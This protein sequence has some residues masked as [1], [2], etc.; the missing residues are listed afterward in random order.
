MIQAVIFDMDG[1]LINSEPYWRLAM[2]EAFQEV[3]LPFTEEN[4]RETTG[5]RIDEVVD[6]WYRRTPWKS[7][8]PQAVSLQ[9]IDL[10]KQHV[11][12]SGIALPGVQ[13]TLDLL[14]DQNLRLALA[15]SS[16]MALIDAVL[17]RLNI[18]SYFEV[19]HSAEFEAYGKPHPQVF[20]ST[21][22]KLN[23]KPENC[24]VIEDSLNG[25]IA[26]KAAKMKVI[27]IP[28]AE[29]LNNPAFAIADRQYTSLEQFQ[30]EHLHTL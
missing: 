20:I 29:N 28:E 8:A 10:V 6:L 18:R 19:V 22:E 23:C 26:G 16:S 13:V 7:K 4:C 9:I 17:D 24:V 1:L 5:F 30:V 11:R 27:A 2:I 15:S 12:A 21:A 14:R 25:I 3:G